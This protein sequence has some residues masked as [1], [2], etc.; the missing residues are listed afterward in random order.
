[1]L[2]K[3]VRHPDRDRSPLNIPLS[4]HRY[5]PEDVQK[6]VSKEHLRYIDREA[7]D[8]ETDPREEVE[9][10]VGK[11]RDKH[12]VWQDNVSASPSTST[13]FESL[14]DATDFESRRVSLSRRAKPKMYCSN[15]KAIVLVCLSLCSSFLSGICLVRTAVDFHDYDLF[16]QELNSTGFYHEGLE[17]GPA[18]DL[19][20]AMTILI[21][22]S[23]GSSVIFL[24]FDNNSK[25]E[26]KIINQR[27]SIAPGGY[28][29]W[30]I[31]PNLRPNPSLLAVNQSSG[32]LLAFSDESKRSGHLPEQQVFKDIPT[33]SPD[34]EVIRLRAETYVVDAKNPETCE[35]T[36]G[37]YDRRKLQFNKN[38]IEGKYEELPL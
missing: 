36:K 5:L 38:V 6:S 10:K 12:V 9:K 35:M 16:V 4:P 8:G 32:N 21:I 34:H 14:V 13:D 26:R 37:E 17:M 11:V 19:V 29:K 23:L 2:S 30:A 20:L 27:S 22:A 7:D 31:P 3:E 1:M 25:I 28:Q 33:K 18:P 24:I 15:Y